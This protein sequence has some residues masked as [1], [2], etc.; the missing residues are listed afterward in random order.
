MGGASP[1]S[2][3]VERDVVA[4]ADIVPELRRAVRVAGFAAVTGTMLPAFAARDAMTAEPAKAALRDRW[5]RRWSDALLTLF[6]VRLETLD[7][8]PPRTPG[9]GRIVVMNH[10]GAVDVGIVLRTFGGQMVSRADLS[11]WP[12]VGVAARRTGTVFV[13]RKDSVSGAAAIRTI[14]DLLRAGA[15]I[16]VFPEG[17]TYEGDPVRPFHPGAFVAALHTGCE[18]LPAA[19]AYQTG[20]GAAFVDETFLS[21]LSRIAKAEPTRVA[22]AVGEPIVVRDNVRSAELRERAHAEVSSLVARA[23]RAV[24]A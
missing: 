22:L 12:L 10:R 9:R 13:D 21:H 4:R 8:V 16:N 5:V 1:P 3:L 19:V 20:S 2:P 6:G 15:S 23:R 14:R 24:D 11:E 18:V 17:T 7:P